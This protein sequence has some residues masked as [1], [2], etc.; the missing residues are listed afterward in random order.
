MQQRYTALTQS[1]SAV[2]S[3]EPARSLKMPPKKIK[4]AANPEALSHSNMDAEAGDEGLQLN[5]DQKWSLWE[6]VLRQPVLYKKGVPGW[7]HRHIRLEA[8]REWSE[9]NGLNGIH[10]I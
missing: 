1:I 2:E 10:H 9:H 8:M 5:L 7:N 4:T 6:Y 3:V